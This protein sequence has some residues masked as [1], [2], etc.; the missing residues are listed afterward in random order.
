MTFNCLRSLTMLQSLF[1]LFTQSLLSRLLSNLG[2]DYSLARNKVGSGAAISRTHRSSKLAGLWGRDIA[3]S[4]CLTGLLTVFLTVGSISPA[5]ASYQY[6]KVNLMGEDFS[7]Q[8]LSD[9][10]FVQA[11]LRDADLSNANLTGI[12][13]FG[14]NMKRANLEGADLRYATLDSAQLQSANLKNAVLEGAFAF[15]TNFEGTNV[16]GAD[17]TDVLLDNE[18]YELLCEVADGVN[19]VTGRETRETLACY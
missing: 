9:S 2:R 14:A 6:D 5:F 13:M 7:N 16:E 17:F 10:S 11:N 19:P 15:R 12:S 1:A 18:M 4:I 3:L 8:D